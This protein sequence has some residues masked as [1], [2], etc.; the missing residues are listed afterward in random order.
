MWYAFLQFWAR[1]LFPMAFRFRFFGKE[2]VPRTGGVILASNHQSFMDPPLAA[3]ALD[4]QVHYMARKS[5]FEHNPLFTALITSLNAFPV[6][7]GRNDPGAVRQTLRRLEAGEAVIVFPEATRT[8]TGE[9]GELNER[10]FAVACRAGVPVVPTLIEG[11]FE[12]WPRSRRL[13]RPR[14]IVVGYGKPLMPGDFDG[15]AE[16]LAAACREALLELQ[17]RA[18]RLRGR[19]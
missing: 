19:M 3:V 9:I 12:S 6:D 5:L 16:A 14:P 10:L 1:I 2:N 4:R 8:H 18:R 7:R 11:A 13:P 17:A 15:D